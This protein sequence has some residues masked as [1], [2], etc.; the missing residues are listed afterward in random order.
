MDFFFTIVATLVV[1]ALAWRYLG[2]YMVAVYEGRVRYLGFLERPIY[3]LLGTAPEREQTWKRYAGSLLVFSGVTLLLGYLIMRIQGLLPLDP[4]HLGGV[5]PALSWNT[6]VSFVTNTNW[7]NYAGETTMTYFTQMSVMMVQQFVS[8][9]VGI[10]VAVALIRGFSR[11]GSPTIGNFWVDTVRGC[12]YVLFPVAFVAGIVFV[13][14]GAVQTLGGPAH[15]QDAL[16]GVTQLIALG[17]VAFMEAIKQLGTNGGGFF[18]ANGAHPFENPT[19]LTNLLSVVLILSIPVALTYVFGKM[20]GSIRQGVA[21]LA[22]MTILFG[23]WLT[24]TAY[25]EHQPNPAVAAAGVAGQ[26][27]GNMEGKE[28]RFGDTQSALYDVTSTQTS[29]GSVDGAN[30]SYNAMGG[31]GLLTGMMLGEVSPG[32]VGSGLYTILLFAI[33]AVFIGGL[34]IGRTPEYLGKKIQAREV[35][36][37]GLGILVMPITVLV[38]TGVAVS[39]HAGRAGPLNAGPHGFSEIL[40]A[41]TSQANNNGSAFAGLNGNTAFYNVTGGLAML[42][43][44]FAIIVPTLAL[45]GALAAKN[46]V[47]ASAGTFRTDNTMFVGLL[48]GVIL[49]VGGLTF[50]PAV[51]LGPIVEQLSHHKFFGTALGPVLATFSTTASS[52][53]HLLS[54]G[55]L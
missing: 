14:Q 33:V 15:V 22:A 25:A 35:K 31:F 49:I 45:A 53:G 32:G 26:P 24:F 4:Q 5:P 1:V 40:Y 54:G 27:G 17:P 11:K 51:S 6:S 43:G 36:L 34:M 20:V 13:G 44:R 21:V 8:A 48:I 28:V 52:V 55:A 37:A 29:T 12:L 10:A 23:A 38:L 46:L 2:Q 9:A 41:F 19:G 16:N 30:D 3:R 47:P 50:F 42:L 39:L 7:Q 18:N